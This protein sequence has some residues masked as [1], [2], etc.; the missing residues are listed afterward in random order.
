MNINIKIQTSANGGGRTCVVITASLVEQFP[1]LLSGNLG[2]ETQSSYWFIKHYFCLTEV[3]KEGSILYPDLLVR[4]IEGVVHKH[5]TPVYCNQ[6]LHHIQS[7]KESALWITAEILCRELMWSLYDLDYFCIFVCLRKAELEIHCF[8]FV[9][10]LL[11]HLKVKLAQFNVLCCL[12]SSLYFL[13]I[14]QCFNSLCIGFS[15]TRFKEGM[16]FQEFNF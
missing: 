6:L 16:F 3:L 4:E 8:F 2:G 7:A 14:K 1:G 9:N 13:A 15:D 12:N 10:S 5:Q 11:V